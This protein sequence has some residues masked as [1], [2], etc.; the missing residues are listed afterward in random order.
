MPQDRTRKIVIA[1]ILGAISIFLGIT[2]WGF[3]PWVGGASITIMTVPVVIGAVLEG[4]VV[5]LAIGLIFGVFSLIQAAA[6]P[7]GPIDV[8]FTNPLVSVLPRLFIAPL[9]WLVWRALQRWQVPGLIASGAAGALTNTVLVL[10]I[11]GVVGA[12]P[13]AT[14]F[15]VFAANG[16]P[17]AI[18]CA[19]LVLLVVAAYKQI[20]IGRKKGANLG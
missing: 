19:L 17:E 6:A 18:I 7:N 15:Y 8:L 14:V 3:L 12:L 2:K 9:A 1:G 10:G 4:P 13:W 20:Q 11:L 16:L 5:G